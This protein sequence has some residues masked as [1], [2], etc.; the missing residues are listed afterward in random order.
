M[1]STLR[2]ARDEQSKDAKGSICIFYE[3]ICANF[4][5]KGR[6]ASVHTSTIFASGDQK[7]YRFKSLAMLP[8]SINDTLHMTQIC[9]L[10]LFTDL[11]YHK[12]PSMQ[13]VYYSLLATPRP[14]T[15]VADYYLLRP[16]FDMLA[17]RYDSTSFVLRD[18]I[19]GGNFGIVYEAVMKRSTH[20][21]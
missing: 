3:D 21:S 11:I 19:G 6:N 14:L 2:E 8:Q 16:L 1:M 18:R 9:F 17:P 5:G 20:P 10:Q 15:T 12:A 4:E 13:L 7:W